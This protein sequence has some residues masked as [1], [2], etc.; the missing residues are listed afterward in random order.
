MAIRQVAVVTIRK[1][2]RRRPQ[3][4]VI[5]SAARDLGFS[6]QQDPHYR[7]K[8][9]RAMRSSAQT[10]KSEADPTPAKGLPT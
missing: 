9:V 1:I 4:F 7:R 3:R 2:S 8:S 10:E 6:R 5:P